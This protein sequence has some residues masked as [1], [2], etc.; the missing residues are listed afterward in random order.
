MLESEAK[1][2]VL[3]HAFF[4]D[5]GATVLLAAAAATAQRVLPGWILY[6]FKG[7]SLTGHRQF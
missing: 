1:L 5:T 2:K 7:L 3:Y 6:H 4:P